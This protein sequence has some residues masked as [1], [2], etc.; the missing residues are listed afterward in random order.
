[1]LLFTV[2][3]SVLTTFVFGLVPALKA[4]RVDVRSMLVQGLAVDGRSH[5]PRRLIVVSEIAMSVVLLVGAGLFVR[6]FDHLQNLRRGFDGHNVL[7]AAL[8]LQDVRYESADGVNGLFEA[9]LARIRQ[10]PGVESA[11]VALTLPYERAVNNSWRR[12]TDSALQP[13][14]VNMT[15]VTPE[16]FR[17]LRIALVRG[18]TFTDRDS[19]DAPPVAIVNRTFAQ[20]HHIM[21]D[22]PGCR[23]SLGGEQL[24]EVV[25]IAE[26]VPQRASMPGFAPIDSIPGVF[27]PA[28]QVVD[29][30]TMH[31]FFSPSW[32]VRTAGPIQSMAAEMQQALRSVDPRF[33]S[34][35]SGPW[36]IC[37]ARR[38]CYSEQ[39]R[40][41]SARWPGSP[42][43]SQRSACMGSSPH[44]WRIGRGSSV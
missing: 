33:P 10:L 2:C 28:A 14:T 35:A 23:L 30:K 43:C 16:Y 36:T 39:L 31:A 12:S 34:I 41:C 38:C 15:H 7:A 44:R 13:E 9:S 22:V 5:W 8:S 27:I 40:S 25:G 24:L 1:V 17:T 3:V 26:D 19:K 32:I 29:F 18:R 42:S 6:T 11:S 4:S 21:E 20:R 37:A